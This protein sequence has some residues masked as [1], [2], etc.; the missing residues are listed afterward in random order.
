MD[1]DT[2]PDLDD[3]PN[4]SSPEWQ[5]C[6][7]VAAATVEFAAADPASL[8]LK[9]A[10]ERVFSAMD[11]FLSANAFN[12]AKIMVAI[13]RIFVNEAVG[14]ATL[15]KINAS[16]RLVCNMAAMVLHARRASGGGRAASPQ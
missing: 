8:E 5:E 7:G 13:E 2:L 4:M 10:V 6:L 15:E 12:E 14:S 11:N 16:V 1:V 3:D 9:N